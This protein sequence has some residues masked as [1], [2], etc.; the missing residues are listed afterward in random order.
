MTTQLITIEQYNLRKATM[1][2]SERAVERSVEADLGFRVIPHGANGFQVQRLDAAG[3][4][5]SVRPGNAE[6]F[7][8]FRKV[9]EERIE[10]WEVSA[11]VHSTAA[12]FAK[13]DKEITAHLA[14]CPSYA[15]ERAQARRQEAGL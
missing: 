13:L 2:E 4:V 9:V 1:V 7:S 10:R 6:E 8:A 12:A 14:S 5:T 15:R 11:R 3:R